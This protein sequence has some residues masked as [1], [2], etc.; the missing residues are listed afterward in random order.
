MPNAKTKKSYEWF[1]KVNRASLNYT[2]ARALEESCGSEMNFSELTCHNGQTHK[3]WQCSH[4]IATFLWESR[5]ALNIKNLRIFCRTINKDK[6]RGPLRDVTN[7]LFSKKLSY[8]NS[9][10]KKPH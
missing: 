4:E 1:I 2:I 8:K 6:S 3:F 10:I 7:I 9:R 5:D